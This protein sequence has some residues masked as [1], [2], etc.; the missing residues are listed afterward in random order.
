MAQG[1]DALEESQSRR[2]EEE[3]KEGRQKAE[4]ELL[5]PQRAVAA[6]ERCG[7]PA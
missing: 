4:Q 6:G 2:L 7:K 1:E 3:K 5:S